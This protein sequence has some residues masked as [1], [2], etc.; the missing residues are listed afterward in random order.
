MQPV[1]TD[2]PK[3]IQW[4]E[5][6]SVGIAALDDEHQRLVGLINDLFD[7]ISDAGGSDTLPFL[8]KTLEGIASYT[9]VHFEHEESTLATAQYPDLEKHRLMHQAFQREFLKMRDRY[10]RWP[11]YSG[12]REIL[13]FLRQWWVSHI[14]R[15]DIA[16]APYFGADSA[17]LR[18]LDADGTPQT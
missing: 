17:T 9:N 4:N 15:V 16:Y 1:H 5:I 3:Y 11:T 14:N 10:M 6:N 7:T 18:K 8:R 13:Q 2:R 12:A